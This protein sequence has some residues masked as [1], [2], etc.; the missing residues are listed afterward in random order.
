[1]GGL[2]ISLFGKFH[3]ECDQQTLAGLDARKVQEMFC[4]LLL[5]RD[6]PHPRETL[7][8]LLWNTTSSAAQS[9]KY[10]RQALWKLQ[11]AID[12]Q[13]EP[14]GTHVL[15]VDLDRV[16]LNPDA[17]LWLDV[18]EFE[19]AFDL[20]RGM[21]GQQ[22]GIQQAQA[23]QRAAQLYQG[24]LLE[25]WY[26]DWC[27][28]ER[29]RLQNVYL[30]MLDK[31]IDYCEERHDYEA[32]LAY[33]TRILRYDPAREC[34]HQRVMRLYYLAGSRTT[35]LRQYEHCVAM[36]E[37]ELD[38]K[39]TKRTVALYEQIRLD[40]FDGVSVAPVEANAT[41]ET[42]ATALHEVLDHL[43]QLRSVLANVQHLVQQD[44]QAIDLA[45]NGRP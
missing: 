4:Y 24:D 10:L 33:A 44:I 13:A 31:L 43:Q 34:T 37:Q 45:L 35:A 15:L 25:G 42:T 14:T 26:Q 2:R 9:K 22:L 18:A 1:M 41:F 40:R 30:V 17:D 23:L 3:V 21:P 7:A 11:T 38:V 19:Q 8:S 6:R 12:P 20:V 28:Y 16:Q 32:G 29:E 39:P 5:Y 36:L 27:L